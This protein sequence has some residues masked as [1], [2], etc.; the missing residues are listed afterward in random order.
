MSLDSHKKEIRAAIH[1]WWPQTL[2]DHWM[3]SEGVVNQVHNDGRIIPQRNTKNFGGIRNA[4]VIKLDTK[5]SV[6]DE[7]FE[8]QF[9]FV[10]SNIDQTVS[11]LKGFQ[12]SGVQSQEFSDRLLE[13]PFD[14]TRTNVLLALLIS[15]AVRAP[16][17][18]N[19]IQLI[20]DDFGA[21]KS[22]MPESLIALNQ[23]GVFPKLVG[24]FL[25]RGKFL[26]LK[27]DQKEFIYGDG[28]FHSFSSPDPSPFHAKMLVPLTPHLCVLYACP[29][30]YR[31]EPRLF[32]MSV[33][34]EEVKFINATTQIYSKNF[35]FYSSQQPHLLEEFTRGEFLIYEHN[36]HD[37]IETLINEIA[38]YLPVR[39]R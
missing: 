35:I 13:L 38:H 31:S 9:D 16:K 1:H 3:N 5:P 23:R 34:E 7:S 19:S 29:T 36:R 11:W 33:T 27:S 25:N 6:W 17:F 30:S 8:G 2:A 37:Y 22:K 12:I 21:P 24:S 4:H 39:L 28:F 10:D 20:I 18:R 14:G 26:I 15:L 32:G